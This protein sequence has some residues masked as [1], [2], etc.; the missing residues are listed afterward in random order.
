[1]HKVRAV[2]LD[3]TGT[4][5]RGKPSLTALLPRAGFSESD[6]L[7]LAATAEQGSE[8]PLA[9]AIVSA[10]RE[11]NLTLGTLG[12]FAAVAGHGVRATVD[13]RTVLI[14]NERLLR[15]HGGEAGPLAEEAARQARLG[16]TPVYVALEGEGGVEP[17]G[18]LAISDTIKPDSAAA[19]EKL[20]ALGL[21]VWML[22]GDNAATAHAVAGQVGIPAERVLAEVLPG[23]KAAAVR[24]LQARG[25][26]VAMVGDGINDAPALAQADLG[27]A[28]GAGS[29]IAMEASDITLVG[30]DL[31]G[32]VTAIALSRRTVQTIR[33]NL[34]WAFAYNVLLIPVA[35]GVLYPWTGATL[36]PELAAGAMALSSVSVVTNSLRLR[37]FRLPED[38]REIAHPPLRRR[39]ADAGYLALLAGIGFGIMGGVF[40]YSWWQDAR[41]EE[42]AVSTSVL[43][44]NPATLT[45]TAG[46][47]YRL[48][49][50]NNASIPHDIVIDGV[51]AGHADT[52]P[53]GRASLTFKI[54]E[55]GVYR[56]YCTLPGHE[57]AG[58]HGTLIVEE[59]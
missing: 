54:S 14:G 56:Y 37:K 57:E 51:S 50:T 55:P 47:T 32:V 34:F 26:A 8:H 5:T 30:G 31:R 23:D 42:I 59:S 36:S 28:M 11:R 18:L 17:L 43:E 58:M 40:G 3:K 35:A 10:A 38:A 9:E 29:D 27:I 49:Y 1:A 6:L 21:E 25:L 46:T 22:T 20:Q 52:N 39:L 16:A 15:E 33:Q 41:A 19:I 45:V 13:G 12:D 53:G 4:I 24:S 2:V 44:F 48:V 7:R